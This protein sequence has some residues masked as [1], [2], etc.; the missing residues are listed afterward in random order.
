MLR[1]S[2]LALLSSCVNAQLTIEVPGG[3]GTITVRDGEEPADE[4]ERFSQMTRATTGHIFNKNELQ[5]FVNVF[6]N[7][8]EC[9]KKTI[10]DNLSIELGGIGVIN[11]LP[12]QAPLEAIDEFL[13]IAKSKGH[14][15]LN[16]EGVNQ[17]LNHFCNQKPCVSTT[18]APLEL[19][20][21]GMGTVSVAFGEEV[22]DGVE[23]FAYQAQQAGLP[24]N[25]E[26]VSQIAS[27]LC[28]LKTCHLPLNLPPV[29]F[30][31]ENNMNNQQET[32]EVKFGEDPCQVIESFS[33]QRYLKGYGYLLE[34]EVKLLYNSFC[35]HNL[36]SCEHFNKKNNKCEPIILNIDD[37]SDGGGSIKVNIGEEPADAVRDYLSN[38]ISNGIISDNDI[39][40]Q[41]IPEKIMSMLC[42]LKPCHKGLDMNPSELQIANIG[43]LVIP[44]GGNPTAYVEDFLE[45]ARTAGHYINAEGAA[46]LM[47]NVCNMKGTA[48][49]TQPLDVTSIELN[50]S[51][52]PDLLV[53]P[54]GEEPADSAA[55]WMLQARS[56][57]VTVTE[58][59]ALAIMDRLCN[60]KKCNKPLDIS[61]L[62]INVDGIGVL[63]IP[64]GEEPALSVTKFL[65]QARS[66]GHVLGS[67]AASNIM[68]AVCQQR[69][70]IAPLDV[71]DYSLNI[72]GVGRFTVAYGEEPAIALHMFV[73]E[74]IRQGGSGL[75][76]AEAANQIMT[77]TCSKVSCFVPLDVRPVSIDIKDM[78]T[79]VV[80]FGFDPTAAVYDFLLSAAAAGHEVTNEMGNQIM[81][82]VCSAGR[83]KGLTYCHRPLDLRPYTLQVEGLGT[84]VVP[85]AVEPAHAVMQFLSEAMDMGHQID[86]SHAKLLMD[87][88][89]QSRKC[90]VP[91][92]TSPTILNISDMGVVKVAFGEEPSTVV[93]KFISHAVYEGNVINTEQAQMIMDHL[94]SRTKC[95]KSLDLSPTTI[96]VQGA[97]VLQVPYSVVPQVAIRNFGNE[98][99][100]SVYAM[101]QV[102]DQ[103]CTMVPCEAEIKPKTA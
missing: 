91:V 51:G 28:S 89:C 71:A 6:C 99:R 33:S 79:V 49:C 96:D 76:N 47:D 78:G 7:E 88:V 82:A 93:R 26:G 14:E 17:V 31:I 15:S 5:E 35:N 63:V 75:I 42:Q 41:N 34:N 4:V 90:N 103:L 64:F 12:G 21:Q 20:I 53:V 38:V 39:N 40:N 101:Q 27:A 92:D 16:P 56:Y 11:V 24:L 48:T 44:L 58:P 66:Q 81:N 70:C 65:L 95:R 73:D 86:A 10:V 3:F 61:P 59:N 52:V 8:I 68:E 84:L 87:N 60:M 85:F 1:L 100:L 30:T 23:R 55:A 67:A 69:P 13:I 72:E 43:S 54:F 9:V 80:P 83:T 19:P 98:H 18:P 22:A 94:C 32:I 50:I 2:I 46:K 25:L 97:G 37:G 57:G 74:V 29:A 36:I 77:E 102:M 45:K 62:Q